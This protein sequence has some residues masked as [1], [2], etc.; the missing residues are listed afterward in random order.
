VGDGAG[1]RVI[2]SERTAVFGD[3]GDLVEERVVAV[4]SGHVIPQE[5]EGRSGRRG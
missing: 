3:V 4:L 5:A 2:V 1:Y